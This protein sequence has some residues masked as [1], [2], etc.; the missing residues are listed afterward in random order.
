METFLNFMPKP[1]ETPELTGLNRLPARATLYPFVDIESALTLDRNSTPWF[2]SLNGEWKFQLVE[3]PEVAGKEFYQESFDDQAWRSITVPGNWTMQ[4]TGDYPQYTNVQMPFEHEPPYVPEKNPTG[5]YR[6]TFTVDASWLNRRTVL[7]FAGVES[8]Y[9]VYVNGK[10]IGFSKDSRTPTEFD[11]SPYLQTGTNTLAV[12]VIRW[13][14]GSFIEDQDHWWM[15]GIHRDVYLYSTNKAFIQDLFVVGELDDAYENGRLTVKTR[16]ENQNETKTTH[17]VGIHLV[18]PEGNTILHED[19]AAKTQGLPIT[20]RGKAKELEHNIRLSFPIETPKKWTAETP[21]LYK[22]LIELKD[23]EGNTVEVA[24]TRIGFRRVE[25]KNKELLINGK[26]VLM[27]GVNRHDHDDTTGKTISREL[28]IKDILL[29]KQFNFN[30][31]RT[32]HYPNDVEWYDLCDEYGLYIIDEANIESHDF[33]DQLCRDP[34]WTPAFLDR[35]MRMVQRDKNHACIIQWSLGNESGYGPNHDASAGWVR[36]FDPSRLLHYEGATREEFG[37]GPVKYASAWGDVDVYSLTKHEAGWGA[38]ATDTYCPMYP[39]VEDMIRWVEEID[40]PRPYIPCEYSHAMGNSNGNLKEYWDA[41]EKYHGLQG[42]FIWDWVDQGLKKV[43][44]NGQAYWAYGGDFGEDKHD[45]DF[46]ING[47]VWPDR[48]P[49]PAMYEFKKL[50]QPIKIEA[51]ALDQGHFKI[52]NN[53]YFTNMDWLQG[54]WNLQ[55]DGIEVQSGELPP[56]SIAPES[57]TTFDIP[58]EPVTKE[59][60]CFINFSITVKEATPWCDANHEI[61]WE[62]FKIPYEAQNK[63]APQL[64]KEVLTT[65]RGDVATITFQELMLVIDKTEG[66]LNKLAIGGTTLFEKLPQLNLYRAAT[67]NDGIRGWTGQDDKAMGQW[68][69]AGLNNLVLKQSTVTDS[70]GRI[71]LEK[72]WVGANESL[73]ISHKQIITTLSE[74]ISVQNVVDVPQGL[75]SL[76]RVGVLFELPAGFEAL[77]WFGRGPHENY[78]DRNAGT[79]VGRYKGTV[80]GQYVPYI[81]PQENGNKTDV[82]WF[83]LESETAGVLFEAE[84]LMEFSVSHFSIEDLMTALHTNELKP[85]PETLVTI[86]AR[87]RGLGTGSCGPDTRQEYCVEPGHYEFTYFI[88]PY[89]K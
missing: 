78:I 82:R 70:D 44:E 33:Y 36:S 18:D 53:Q 4:D 84:S 63:P 49:H 79:P 27:K 51:L 39:T 71:T 50:V 55:V 5:L 30:A 81:L 66:T 37:Q 72:I 85:R 40:D 38:H 10:Q 32:S 56:F 14:D 69:Q 75:P 73:E 54:T 74:G 8:A 21:W 57:E 60:E 80:S 87:Q 7:H 48:T 13:S 28:M 15:A 24:S 76:A 23:A 62:Q 9:F 29:L 12:M 16:V 22:V 58:L 11:I 42:G 6:T 83:R 77:E 17:T 34:R 2:Q 88:K 67:D 43:D 46:C 59:G 89:R 35:V 47:L 25:L 26:A 61:A 3:K 86:D 20:L 65:E 41:I 52:K 45:F 31:V 68:H 64:A 1:W 19:A